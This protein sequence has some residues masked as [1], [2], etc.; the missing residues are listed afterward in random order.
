MKEYLALFRAGP[1]S[2]HKYTVEGIENQNFDY[3]LSYFGDD[4]PPA[5]GAVFVHRQKGPKWPGLEQT[6]RQNWDVVRAY[7]YVWLPDDDLLC[8]PD[9][10]SRLF[11]NCKKMEVDIGQPALTH[12]SY[13]THVVT[14]QH[15]SFEMR[16]TN[17]V[18]I[19]APVFSVGFLDRVLDTFSCN[20]SGYGL[21]AL[22]PRMSRLGNVVIF[23][24]VP[25][26][27]T[28]PVGGDNYVFNKASGVPAWM[29]GAICFAQ[30][31]VETPSDY[32]IC[33]GGVMK[34]GTASA[35]GG[36]PMELERLL[37]MLFH[38]LGGAP[39]G[40]TQLTQYVANHLDYWRG[41]EHGRVSYPRDLIR[42]LL[43]QKLARLGIQ[44]G[45]PA[46]AKAA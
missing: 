34:D 12:D 1:K 6:L 24:D 41:R 15:K 38:S 36:N 29:E 21:D 20:L 2:L 18:E 25:V 16:F 14:L 28:R 44:A 42:I 46:L 4:E 33:F 8:Q 17:F 31:F 11:E 35:L 32:H 22:W 37:S 45:E 40:A 9:L 19:M 23:D 43:N 27:H 26:K 30:S 3:A 13:F 39:C 5:D 7:K 10:V